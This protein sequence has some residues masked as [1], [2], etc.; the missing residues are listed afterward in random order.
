M[1]GSIAHCHGSQAIRRSFAV[2]VI[3]ALLC[4]S[5]SYVDQDIVQP[6]TIIQPVLQQRLVE[7]PIIRTRLIKQPIRRTVINRS[8]IRPHLMSQRHTTHNTPTARLAMHPH[9]RLSSSTRHLAT[10]C[11][12]LPLPPRL[13]ICLRLQYADAADP[14]A[15]QPGRDTAQDHRAEDHTRVVQAGLP[16]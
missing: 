10:H 1:G 8:V 3:S 9:A 2:F 4:L 7:Q 11:H 13:C 15:A 6:K 16:D 12:S 14:G 5:C